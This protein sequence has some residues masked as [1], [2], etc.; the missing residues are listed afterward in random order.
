MANLLGKTSSSISDLERGKVQVSASELSKIA[1]YLNVPISSFYTD[2]LDE[3]YMLNV[4]NIIARQPEATR[5]STF[6]MMNLFLEAQ[7]MSN[8]I[9]SDPNKEYSP[10]E[11]GEMVGKILTFQSHFSAMT[12]KFDNLIKELVGILKDYG[13]TLPID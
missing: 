1:N 4:V 12:N 9:L 2:N 3:E 5:V 11:L 6:A 7:G 13:I 8:M 10:D